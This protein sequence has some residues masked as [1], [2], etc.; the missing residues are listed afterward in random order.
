MEDTPEGKWSCPHCESEGGQEPDEDEHQE[1]CRLIIVPNKFL[2]YNFKY[3]NILIF[4]FRVC[5]DGGELLCCDS[6]PAAYHTFCLSPP[7]TDVPDGDWKC[8]RCSVR[9]YKNN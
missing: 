8:P 4:Y 2:Y 5:K 6:C 7:I 1:F 9:V 3:P